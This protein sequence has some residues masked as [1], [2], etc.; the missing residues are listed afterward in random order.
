MIPPVGCASWVSDKCVLCVLSFWNYTKNYFS[1]LTL[2]KHINSHKSACTLRLEWPN[3]NKR[4]DKVKREHTYVLIRTPKSTSHQWVFFTYVA[5]NHSH[6]LL[7]LVFR[8]ATWLV[9]TRAYLNPYSSCEISPIRCNCNFIG[10]N[11]HTCHIFVPYTD[12][13]SITV[14]S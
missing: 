12:A 14:I 8:S 5:Y 1:A 2:K 13:C 11:L 6:V 4:N 10:W 7:C 3:E 9:S